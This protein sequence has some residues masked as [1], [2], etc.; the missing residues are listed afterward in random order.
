[1]RERI[2]GL[3]VWSSSFENGARIDTRFTK[4]GD[5]VSPEIAWDGAPPE[6]VEFAVI[7]HDPDAPMPWYWDHW[8]V[9]G[10][11]ADVT[12]LPEG[13][14]GTEYQLGETTFGESDYGGPGPPPGHGTHH[15]LFWV[16]ALSA[17]VDGPLT[18]RAFLE[19]H[20][21]DILA[22]ERIVCTYSKDA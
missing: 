5:D 20:G 12:S 16:Y 7:C 8:T 6:T 4:Y 19:R 1:M 14:R 3:R 21:A 10:I 11:P 13:S 22:Q 17:K 2:V 15:Y 9:T 18:R